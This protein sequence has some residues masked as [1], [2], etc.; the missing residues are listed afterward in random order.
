MKDYTILHD[1]LFRRETIP[2]S[3]QEYRV[4]DKLKSLFREYVDW[5]KVYNVPT[6]SW[7]EEECVLEIGDRSY[8][9]KALPNVDKIIVEGKIVDAYVVNDEIR[10]SRDVEYPIVF[11]EFPEEL[12]ETKYIV[13][14]LSRRGAVAVIFYDRFE[15][16]YRRSVLNG[17]ENYSFEHGS[18]PPIP[19][20]SIKREDYT[21]IRRLGSDKLVL[22]INARV[23]HGLE[24]KIVVAGINGSGENEIHVTA[25]HDHWFTGFSDNLVGLEVLYQVIKRLSREWS[26]VNLVFI[27]FS[28][29]EI[30]ALNYASWYWA[31]GSRY[32]LKI[33][34]EKNMLEKVVVDVNVDAIYKL[35]L[36]IH[37]NPS[38]KPCIDRVSRK[39]TI[40]YRGY[41]HMD[42]DSFSYTIHGVPALTITSLESMDPIYHSNHDDGRDFNYEVLEKTVN[43]VIDL[44]KCFD[45]NRP[46]YDALINHVRGE[47]GD[48]VPLEV[49]V[50]MTKIEALG[51]KIVDEDRRIRFVTRFLTSVN[52]IP[53]VK[54]WYYTGILGDIISIKKILDE[55][56]EFM[57]REIR[58]KSFDRTILHIILTKYNAE[59][60]RRLMNN[61]MIV[62]ANRLNHLFEEK[63][64]E[65]L[66]MKRSGL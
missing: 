14:E 65:E 34:D 30:G 57:G 22:R 21:E 49:K 44:I 10:L 61:Y 31:W 29:E 46:R 62:E 52:Y 42:F 45:N 23:V 40:K 12:D 60:V 6:D 18:P 50:L 27:S 66:F 53:S 48:D 32:Y 38:L 28:S 54:L 64:V 59:K 5:V 43:T 1:P 33:L 56:E 4:V 3:E 24:S 47:L 25:H 26:G 58:L 63:L 55:L 16:R 9:C 2:G 19:A 7:F 37:G 8:Q 35:P 15:D 11:I 39:N 17:D 36:E 51:D 13:L 41:D 20:V